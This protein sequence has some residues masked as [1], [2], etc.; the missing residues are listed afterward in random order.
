MPCAKRKGRCWW[1]NGVDSS[2]DVW[3]GM[4]R[5]YRSWCRW[6]HTRRSLPAGVMPP[7]NHSTP[8]SMVC[9]GCLLASA[10]EWC[11][12][13]VWLLKFQMGCWLIFRSCHVF[14]FFLIFCKLC[15]CFA[16]FWHNTGWAKK[17]ATPLLFLS[18]PI[19]DRF[20]KFF[21]GTGYYCWFFLTFLF[22]KV[23]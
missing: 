19:I 16:A 5:V 6:L 8:I 15:F 2:C 9:I 7:S 18:L 12:T 23:V 14:S 20:S 21:T 3:F 1:Q 11:S 4:F 22:R 17:H 13:S 10:N